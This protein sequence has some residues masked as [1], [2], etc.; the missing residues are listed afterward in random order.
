MKLPFDNKASKANPSA[1][2]DS[3][4]TSSTPS[5]ASMGRSSL[6][7]FQSRAWR[8]AGIYA[9]FATLWIYFSDQALG[10]LITEPEL[11]VRLSVYKGIAF[12]ALTSVLLLLL[13]LKAFA[14]IESGYVTLKRQ[15]DEIERFNRLYS[16]LSHVNQAIVLCPDRDELFSRICRVLVDHGAFRMVW[17]GW[18]NP[19]DSSVVP[20]A[21]YG[22]GYPYI[23]HILS[24]LQ[25]KAARDSRWGKVFE[26]GLTYICNDLSL[27]PDTQPW[28]EEARKYRLHASAALPVRVNGEVCGV[29]NVYASETGFF[30][31]REVDLLEEATADVAFALDKLALEEERRQARL[32]A[33][34]ESQFS[35]AMIESMPGILYFYD[36]HGRFLRWNCNFETVS[37]YGAQEIAGMHPLQ[38]FPS[39]DQRPVQ[40]R[41]A[42]VF[43]AGE[44]SVE[45]LFLARDGTLTP[46]FFTGKR[47]VYDGKPCLVGMGIDISERKKAEDALRELNETLEYKVAERTTELQVAVTRAEAADRI[48]SAF[49]ATMS[50]ELRTPLNSIIGF[51]GILLQE[52]A[53]PL[54]P[55]QSKQLGMVRGSARH[56]LELINDV[57]DL[58]KIE[59]GQLDV[60]AEP[61]DLQDALN[62]VVASITP[63]AEKKQL[64]IVTAIPPALPEMV[65]DRRRVEQILINLLNNAI[66]FTDTGAITLKVEV[67]SHYCG[68]GHGAPRAGVMLRVA[69]TGM[70]IRAEDLSK[71]FQPFIQL[72]SG[73]TRQHDGTGLG[74]TICR[75]LADLMGGEIT[76]TSQWSVGSEFTLTLP[77]SVAESP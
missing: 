33:E 20:V 18:R 31:D 70:G 29:L 36:E 9:I 5:A 48:K 68:T 71:L 34:R 51:T 54:N 72:D 53:G 67:V 24:Q 41:I 6:L 57:L 49:L 55:E 23:E 60:R 12:V 45:A 42:E 77:L 38:F 47:V 66:K 25:G 10:L 32:Q 46:Y 39:D 43:A 64:N 3:L 40:E 7:P 1:G 21:R 73:L 27:D 63:L 13:M 22:E 62:R 52:L 56:L 61:F 15:K 37:G 35:S 30:R 59:A 26:E 44:S 8:I 50:H 58:S 19:E 16:A 14:A 76:V 28:A 75:R 4:V 2:Q 65:G 17:V 74:L 69:D 11:L